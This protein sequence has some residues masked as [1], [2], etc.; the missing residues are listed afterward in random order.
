MAWRSCIKAVNNMKDTN[1]FY[2]NFYIHWRFHC[3]FGLC[4]DFLCDKLLTPL[5]PKKWRTKS[6]KDPKLRRD[7]YER[8]RD[9][10]LA[11]YYAKMAMKGLLFCKYTLLGF[12]LARFIESHGVRLSISAVI[13][14]GIITIIVF[15]I[16]DTLFQE[17]QYRKYFNK[18]EKKDASWKRIWSIITLVDVIFSFACLYLGIKIGNLI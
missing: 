9:F 18:Y 4:V 16:D 3:S 2:A 5:I 15:I 14:V 10:G 12:P 17:S 1:F 6:M 8:K 7:I 13:S 11:V